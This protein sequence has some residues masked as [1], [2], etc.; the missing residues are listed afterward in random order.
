MMNIE[1]Y[2]Q[3]CGGVFVKPS[4]PEENEEMHQV[5]E[6]SYSKDDELLILKLL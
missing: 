1:P 3:G 5:H 4:L 6:L 2:Y